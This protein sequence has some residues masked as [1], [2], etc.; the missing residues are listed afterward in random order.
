MH[1][2]W[3]VAILC[4]AIGALVAALALIWMALFATRHC[5]ACNAPMPRWSK[6]K[7]YGWHVTY[8]AGA[9][10]FICGQCKCEMTPR[11]KPIEP[12]KG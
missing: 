12:V 9:R 2:A 10:I 1:K 4:A 11:G 5:P 6:M 8:R 7:I 3:L